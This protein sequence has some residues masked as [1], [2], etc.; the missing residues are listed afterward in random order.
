[1]LAGVRETAHASTITV[2]AGGDF[3]AALE[4]ARPGDTI[5]LEAGASFLGP[6]SLPFKASAGTDSDWITI[7][8]SAPDSQ[9]P[10]PSERITPA[11]AHLLP[12]LLAP[13]NSSALT[14]SAR[15]HHYRFLFVEFTKQSPASFVNDLITLGEGNQRQNS[16]DLVPHHLIIDRCY[17]HGDPHSDLKR[18]IALNSA[19]TSILNSHIAEVKRVGQETQAIL[20]WNGPGPYQIINNHLEAAGENLMFGGADPAIPE[21]VPSDI[22]IRRNLLTKPLRWREGDPSYGGTKWTV[23][24]LF[25][26]KAGRRIVMDGNILEHN[27]VESQSGVAVLMKSVNADGGAPWSVVEEVTFTNNIVRGVALAINIAGRASVAPC[28]QANRFVISN[29]LFEDIDGGKW[30]GG[31]GDFLKVTEVAGVV[32]EHNTVM[33]TGKV[34]ETYGEVTTGLVFRNNIAAHNAYGIKADGV[35]PGIDTLRSYFPGYVFEKNLIA[36]A[37][38]GSYPRNNFYPNHLGL[39]GFVDMTRK[40][41][42]LTAASRFRGAGTDGKDLGCDFDALA[43][44]GAMSDSR[45]NLRTNQKR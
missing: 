21:L 4:A 6:F 2:P 23:K 29:N 28:R 17:I 5:L 41:Y 42:R 22:E 40:D 19:H 16:L 10:A 30:G 12:K 39:I 18:G 3:Q 37:D 24:N 33:Q 45:A 1:M 14:T 27:W 26:L 31:S 11:F 8:S 32:V 38:A 9:L 36:G 7:R 15:A 44:A 34:I 43:K 35:S 13:H 25:E 20:G